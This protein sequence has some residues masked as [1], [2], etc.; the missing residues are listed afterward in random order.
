MEKIFLEHHHVFVILLSWNSR[1]SKCWHWEG[2]WCSYMDRQ[3]PCKLETSRRNW[4]WDTQRQNVHMARKPGGLWWECIAQKSQKGKAWEAQCCG[5]GKGI[6]L[7][8]LKWPRREWDMSGSYLVTFCYLT[9]L[10]DRQQDDWCLH[11]KNT[12][13]SVTGQWA[14]A[15]CTWSPWSRPALV[16]P[17]SSLGTAGCAH[18]QTCGYR[19]SGVTIKKRKDRGVELFHY[20]ILKTRGSW[21]TTTTNTY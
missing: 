16:W 4:T 7:T 15:G 18:M 17:Q 8:L 1:G 20:L 2:R 13:C 3:N 21:K 10:N 11:I 14:E 19:I 6:T 12:H 5:H 9:D